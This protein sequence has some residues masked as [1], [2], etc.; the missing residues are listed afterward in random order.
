MADQQGGSQDSDEADI[1]VSLGPASPGLQTAYLV[2]SLIVI[3][4]ANSLLI[5]L[6]CTKDHLRQPR[7]YLRFHLAAND[8]F[9]T[10]VLI[11]K[12]I[13][14]ILEDD[15]LRYR[16][17]CGTERTVTDS[18]MLS[19]YGVYLLMA[20]DIYYFICYP[21]QYR[22]KITTWRAVPLIL[23]GQPDEDISCLMMIRSFPPALAMK[24]FGIVALVIGVMVI[25]GLYYIV[26]KEAKRQQERDE[27][28]PVKV[29]KTKGFKTMAP[30]AIVLVVSVVTSVFLAIS[31]NAEPSEVVVIVQQI[32]ILLYLTVSPMLNPIIYSLRL[33]EFRRALGEMC[34]RAPTAGVA[35]AV[36]SQGRARVIEVR[37]IDSASNV[38]D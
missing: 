37:A 2:I 29:Y 7:Y 30:H 9:Y 3:L 27:Q 25:V 6:V 31:K 35:A 17:T 15:T 8:I 12:H 28:R 38:R 32:A 33:P 16:P 14:D 21:L 20:V 18:V 11:P 26:L 19:A 4:A 36:P 24:V 23:V 13:R 22:N 10:A 34:G 5:L 1:T